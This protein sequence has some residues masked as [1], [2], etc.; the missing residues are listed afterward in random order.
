ML[1]LAYN[2]ADRE[3]RRAWLGL[4]IADCKFADSQRR[5]QVALE[6]QRRGRQGRRDVVESE[7][8]PIAREKFRHVDS[9][10]EQ[11]PNGVRIFDA[12]ESGQNITTGIALRS[13][14]ATQ[15]CDQC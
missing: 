8:A 14:G 11:I 2:R 15:T 5:S 10:V 6:Q 9:D 13:S 4:R 1:A 3:R 7:I 12:I